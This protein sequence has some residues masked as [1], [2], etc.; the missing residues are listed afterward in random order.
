MS[1]KE[2][3]SAVPEQTPVED[4]TVTTT[5]ENSQSAIQT[6]GPDPSEAEEHARQLNMIDPY[7]Y[8]QYKTVATFKWNT[9]A[10]AGTPLWFIELTP[11]NIHEILAYISKMYATW[12]GD[13]DFQTIVAGTGFNGGRLAVVWIPPNVKVTE[14]KQ[15][16]TYP[17]ILIDP[18]AQN[19]Q[20]SNGSDFRQVAFHWTNTA[21]TTDFTTY[22]AVNGRGG[23]LAIFVAMPLIVTGSGTN[24]VEVMVLGKCADNFRFNQIIDIP[25][26][27]GIVAPQFS[28]TD[29][30]HPTFPQ[31]ELDEMRVSTNFS[32][33]WQGIDSLYKLDGSPLS[34]GVSN[35]TFFWD[36]SHVTGYAFDGK[37]YPS[38]NPT[39][40]GTCAREPGASHPQ[41]RVK[42]GL[43]GQVFGVVSLGT[44]SGGN[45]QEAV[46]TELQA[47]D[48]SKPLSS[49][50]S[51]YYTLCQQGGT[52]VTSYYRAWNRATG[53]KLKAEHLEPNTTEVLDGNTAPA[54]ITADNG[55]VIVY[56][57]FANDQ[58]GFGT[59]T[60]HGLNTLYKTGFFHLEPID[61]VEQTYVFNVID[62]QTKQ[63]VN[64][65][66]LR[67]NGFFT[68]TNQGATV[69][70]KLKEYELVFRE[71]L[72][73]LT[74]LPEVPVAAANVL[75]MAERR[76]NDRML[77]ALTAIAGRE[78]AL[79]ALNIQIEEVDPNNQ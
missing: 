34:T 45:F 17:Y 77:A 23:S 61:G 1:Q 33:N 66:R 28:F 8:T 47:I 9:G 63:V 24:F 67:Q 43:N 7:F 15:W 38:E 54:E 31:F 55:E 75:V 30:N 56:F 59:L 12:S 48:C 20:P 49:A 69:I 65:V 11:D 40:Y 70:Y 19:A 64:V 5:T 4:L 26:T 73:N 10:G 68:T 79:E 41:C 27:V 32:E 58:E 62:K 53:N 35:R 72:P 74:P 50:T 60:T 42:L 16:S 52:Y 13:F 2:N 14:V 71:I 57:S 6:K 21:F 22:E 25:S 76:Q 51:E 3:A 18:K 39:Q 37:G 44:I 78:R 29:I 36:T 46:R